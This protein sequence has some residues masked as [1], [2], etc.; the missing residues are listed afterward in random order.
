MKAAHALHTVH[1]VLRL[2]RTPPTLADSIALAP[3]GERIRRDGP[4]P[5]VAARLACQLPLTGAT[6]NRPGA[7]HRAMVL[8]ED[9]KPFGTTHAHTLGAGRHTLPRRARAIHIG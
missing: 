8:R 6:L 2:A 9:K 3:C 4:I 1:T 7:S 5:V